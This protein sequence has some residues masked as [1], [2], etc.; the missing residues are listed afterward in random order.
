MIL[1]NELLIRISLL[2]MSI[3][4]GVIIDVIFL[5]LAKDRTEQM[6]SCVH[7]DG[8]SQFVIMKLLLVCIV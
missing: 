3:S 6:L 5:N 1:S 2:T 8:A 7:K 4:S